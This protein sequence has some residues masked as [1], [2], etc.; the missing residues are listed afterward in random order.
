MI[1]RPASQ[2]CK[3]RCSNLRQRTHFNQTCT[4][5]TTFGV[6]TATSAFVRA[7]FNPVLPILRG[8]E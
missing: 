5:L 1:K 6:S 8:S 7:S 4:I 2:T 3:R